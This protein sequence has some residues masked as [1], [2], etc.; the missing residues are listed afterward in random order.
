MR[1]RW[2]AVEGLEEEEREK[3]GDFSTGQIMVGF[4]AVISS[5][6]FSLQVVGGY[7]RV[8]VMIGLL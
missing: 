5:L 8:C 4:S 2:G 1:G 6:G 3:P 7:F